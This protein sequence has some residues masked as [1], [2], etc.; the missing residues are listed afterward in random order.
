MRDY[1]E[2]G[3]FLRTRDRTTEEIMSVL[4][5]MQ[6]PASAHRSLVSDYLGQCDLVKFAAVTWPKAE[7][8]RLL[9]AAEH[10]FRESAPATAPAAAPEA[11]RG[12]GP[13]PHPSPGGPSS[14]EGREAP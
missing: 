7:R 9:D 6:A 5:T 3:L 10:L 14:P 1:L 8:E 4:K 2:E 13:R 12:E 11:P